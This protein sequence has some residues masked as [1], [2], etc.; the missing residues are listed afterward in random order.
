MTEYFDKD[1]IDRINE[2][3]ACFR[4]AILRIFAFFQAL[5]TVLLVFGGCSQKQD[6][7]ILKYNVASAAKTLDPQ[8][9][10]GSTAVTI[11][12]N[13]FEGLLRINNDGEL[14]C[15]A[16][17]SY[18][19]SS[20]GRIYIFTLRDGLTWSDGETK[21]T[22]RDFEFAFERLLSPQTASPYAGNY[23]CIKN[24]EAYL[25]GEKS[26]DTLGISA[27]GLTL[28]FVLEYANP[29]FPYMLAASAAMPCNEE[30]FTQS[31]GKYGKTISDIIFNGPFAANTY[32]DGRY[33]L[34]RRNKHY[35][36][37]PAAFGVNLYITG[38]S[39]LE[40]INSGK[41]DIAKLDHGDAEN[42]DAKNF[43]VLSY[44][45]ILWTIAFNTGSDA[46]HSRYLRLAMAQALDLEDAGSY[47]PQDSFRPARALIP[48]AVDILGSGYRELAGESLALSCDPSAAKEYV[49]LS[50]GDYEGGFPK[51]TI[52]CPDDDSFALLCGKLQREWQQNIA[53]FV[54]I[55][56]VE[57]SKLISRVHSGDYQL[58][59][60]P[61]SLSYNSPAAFLGEYNT[62]ENICRYY[63]GADYVSTYSEALLASEPERAAQ[64]FRSLEQLLIEDAVFI[65]LY[66]QTSSY[67]VN[68]EVSGLY[69]RPFSDTVFFGYARRAE[70]AK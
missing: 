66:Y 37:P 43:D 14:E 42:I 17:E 34:L 33:Y 10:I 22:A 63:C 58:A 52:L 56:R 54:N 29:Y 59:I 65:P 24:A 41:A 5:V 8:L 64:L 55:E 46:M 50:Y 39:G 69:L 70:P 38:E 35:H 62:P 6:E 21:L 26:A 27:Q 32:K 19:V 25:A 2:R 9:A 7:L 48:S 16:A 12:E 20:D 45:D 15:A 40:R 36:T 51:F 31:R 44:E 28:T 67:A 3:T 68:S 49:N 53:I 60:L 18:S 13:C 61:L 11:I 57:L 23:T 47:L 4:A 1:D 30:F